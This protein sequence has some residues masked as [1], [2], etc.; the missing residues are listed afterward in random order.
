MPQEIP[1]TCNGC[2]KK[3]SIKHTLSCPKGGLV[4]AR[5]DATAKE[6]GVLGSRDLVPSTITYEPKTNSRTVEGERT[7][8]GA[9]QEGREA[10]GGADTVEEAQGGRARTVNGAARLA[11]Q[12]GQ[13]EAL[14]ES[15]ADISDHG[16]WKRGTTAML[17]SR[18]F[19]L[20]AGSYLRMTLEKA[21][22]KV[23]KENKD[24]YFQAC[25][26]CRRNFT[27]MVYSADGIPVAR[28]AEDQAVRPHYCP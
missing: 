4:L 24:L 10:D 8:A 28:A 1:T 2:G 9:R 26:E 16:F 19:N 3:F 14:A 5:H 25:L 7:G 12:P 17:D 20:D 13:V 22:A 27:P 21:L 6:W 11:G 23:E 15:R 18:I